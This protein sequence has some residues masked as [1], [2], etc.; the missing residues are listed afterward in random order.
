MAN[1]LTKNRHL[2]PPWRAKKHFHAL[3]LDR[4]FSLTY[5]LMPRAHALA[6][7]KEYEYDG[8]TELL[9]FISGLT[10]Q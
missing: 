2:T 4:C 6:K 10:G 3:P 8:P 5:D 9:V 7:G 1:T